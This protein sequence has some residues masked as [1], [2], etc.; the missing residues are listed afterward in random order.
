VVSKSGFVAHVGACIA[1]LPN[2]RDIDVCKQPWLPPG[3]CTFAMGDGTGG[4]ETYLTMTQSKEECEAY[5]KANE[6]SANGATWG[7]TDKKCF[8]EYGMTGTCQTHA[9]VQRSE[10]PWPTIV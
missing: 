3:T 4:T 6:P 8:A 1:V 2:A 7:T 10:R 9:L 5:V